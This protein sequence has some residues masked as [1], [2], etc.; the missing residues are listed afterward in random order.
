MRTTRKQIQL[1]TRHRSTCRLKSF[2]GHQQTTSN[3]ALCPGDNTKNK[4]QKTK[5]E[6][7][8]E[9]KGGDKKRD[10]K[11]TQPELGALGE[12]S[13]AGT[14]AMAAGPQLRTSE[15]LLALTH[16]PMSP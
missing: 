13:G 1:T 7:K 3:Q 6:N 10:N 4:K 11:K 16:K 5:Q 2:E 14:S 15:R 9:E 8:K 12:L